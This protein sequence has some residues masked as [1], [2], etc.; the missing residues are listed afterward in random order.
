[1]RRPAPWSVSAPMASSRQGRDFDVLAQALAESRLRVVCPDVVGRGA[2]TG[3]PTP[4]LPGSADLCADMLA[5]LAHLKPTLWI[6]WHQ[7]GGLIG[8]GRCAGGARRSTRCADW[9]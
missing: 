6:G 3:W 8:M 4:G 7:H 5:L 2:V 1:M 9:C